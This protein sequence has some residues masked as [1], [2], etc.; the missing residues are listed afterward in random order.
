MSEG[1]SSTGLLLISS[2]NTP[3][4][5]H[6]LSGEYRCLVPTELCRRYLR[7]WWSSLPLFQSLTQTLCI[8]HYHYVS[9]TLTKMYHS[10]SGI[11]VTIITFKKTL[12]LGLGKVKRV[13][14]PLLGSRCFLLPLGLG[15]AKRVNS[16]TL[17]SR[18]FLQRLPNQRA[19][20]LL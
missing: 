15:K 10:S 1:L 20:Y 18:C 16:T 19:V 11:E 7:L 9:Y 2:C 3:F 12:T 17:R 4:A 6:L 14:S 8:Y 13:N 5:L